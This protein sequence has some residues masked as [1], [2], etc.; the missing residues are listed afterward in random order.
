MNIEASQRRRILLIFRLHFQ[1]HLVLIRGG[2][3]RRDLAGAVGAVQSIFN[4]LHGDA[5]GGCLVAIDLNVK[6]RVLNLNI[7]GHIQQLG[8]GRDLLL[9]DLSVA[10]EFIAIR[11]LQ[12]QLIRTLGY[13]AAN[14]DQRRIL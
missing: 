2:I 5:Q 12:G 7:A 3:N 4:L 13:L 9:Q 1:D 8:Q 10:V 6:L 14:L 11:P